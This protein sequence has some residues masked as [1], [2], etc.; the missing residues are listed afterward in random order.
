MHEGFFFHLSLGKGCLFHSFVQGLSQRKTVLKSAAKWW[1]CW[2]AFHPC[3]EV[4]IQKM[5]DLNK[6]NVMNL[7]IY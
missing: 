2:M 4:I 5:F 3:C 7:F 6:Y 1:S